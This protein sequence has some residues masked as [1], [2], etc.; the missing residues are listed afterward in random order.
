MPLPALIQKIH[1]LSSRKPTD[2]DACLGEI[3]TRKPN[4]SVL[5]A[6][7]HS[8]LGEK[9]SRWQPRAPVPAAGE[10]LP[11]PS[12]VGSQICSGAVSLKQTVRVSCH[13]HCWIKYNKPMRKARM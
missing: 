1:G 5:S 4:L 11:S 2:M 7:E 13:E 8:Y 12:H 3:M 6:S 9:K 10:Q